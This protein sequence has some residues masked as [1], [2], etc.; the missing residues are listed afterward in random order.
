MRHHRGAVAT[1]A[2]LLVVAACD[3]SPTA[4]DELLVNE[5]IL[6]VDDGTF[7][8]SHI[9]H[10][11]GAPALRAGGGIG[12]TMHFTSIRQSAD[13]HEPLPPG[14]WFT[15]EGHPEYNV[16][17]VIE[18]TT[19]ARW[20]GDRVRGTLEGRRA[21]ASRMSFVVRRGT[22]TIYEAPPLNFIVQPATAAVL[23]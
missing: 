14:N 8:F 3:R 19:I 23:P 6:E 7:A 17:V 20:S 10:W 16:R 2:S 4:P 18:D 13:E 21:G 9:D 11:H 15:L 22:T 5:I 1:L 12:M